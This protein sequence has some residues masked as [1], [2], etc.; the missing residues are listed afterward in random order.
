LQAA[1]P[2]LDVY[3]WGNLDLIDKADGI[4]AY[5]YH[6]AIENH[7]AP[8]HWTEKLADPFL[9]LTLPFYAGCPN[10]ADYFPP[11]SF[12]PLDLNDFERALV[13]IRRAIA[14]DAYTQRL[15]A[16]REAR[17]RVME[18]YNFFAVVSEL[19]EA[20]HDPTRGGATGVRMLPRRRARRVTPL[21]ALRYLVENTKVQAR[22][23]WER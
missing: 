2:E 13:T 12:I 21:H 10:A 6:L 3:G 4:D 19:I 1:L 11:D 14:E 8:H 9:G 16:I 17:R 23:R 7:R 20:R 5:R 15:P 22:S 18:Q